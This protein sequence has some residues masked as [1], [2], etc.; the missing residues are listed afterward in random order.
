M[1][2]TIN[3]VSFFLG[4][5]Y[6]KILYNLIA[7]KLCKT[8]NLRENRYCSDASL[9]IGCQAMCRSVYCCEITAPASKRHFSWA[10]IVAGHTGS[11]NSNHRLGN[12]RRRGLLLLNETM[13]EWFWNGEKSFLQTEKKIFPHFEFEEYGKKVFTLWLSMVQ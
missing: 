5:W 8:V 9:T 1:E 11:V 10:V 4:L 12:R 3:L 13:K 7:G 6:Q 2:D